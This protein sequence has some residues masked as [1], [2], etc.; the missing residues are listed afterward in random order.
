MSGPLVFDAGDEPSGR[1]EAWQLWHG[2]GVRYIPDPESPAYAAWWAEE[3]PGTRPPVD[4]H[5]SEVEQAE[6]WALQALA[7]GEAGR[8]FA[9]EVAQAA[10]VEKLTSGGPG[11]FGLAAL[12][13]V[14][15]VVVLMM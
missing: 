11:C 6:L 8:G 10:T 3:Y 15:L 4:V 13:G 9:V 5:L 14:V 12:V 2:G 1:G 7:E